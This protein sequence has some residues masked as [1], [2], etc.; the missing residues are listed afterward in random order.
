[1]GRQ[2]FYSRVL[3]RGKSLTSTLKHQGQMGNCSQRGLLRALQRS[4]THHIHILLT[5]KGSL[6]D[7]LTCSE[8]VYFHN[9]C[10]QA[11]GRIGETSCH[12]SPGRLGT[13]RPM[14]QAQSEVKA[15]KGLQGVIG[16]WDLLRGRRSW[17]PM[18][19]VTGTAKVY[20]CWEKAV[21]LPPSAF[22]LPFDSSN[23]AHWC[24]SD[25]KRVSL[26]SRIT[27]KVFW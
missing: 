13:E 2:T 5:T 6:L 19:Q 21:E 10:Q 9:G 17:S 11:G 18:S 27:S 20:A 12:L 3:H 15:L 26:S 25:S 16:C 24:C 1:M 23:P 4:E 8:A 14:M 22:L 7:W